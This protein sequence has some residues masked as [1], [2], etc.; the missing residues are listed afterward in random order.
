M[1]KIRHLVV[2]K[3][4]LDP[5]ESLDVQNLPAVTISDTILPAL[6]I[7]SDDK[8][9]TSAV[10]KGNNGKSN[11]GKDIRAVGGGIRVGN[12]KD[13]LHT[14]IESFNPG[15]GS[16]LAPYSTGIC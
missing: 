7:A 2:D 6:S 4:N 9:I 15:D 14:N 3:R 16:S 1:S 11:S 13:N 8:S 5:A 12:E 10:D